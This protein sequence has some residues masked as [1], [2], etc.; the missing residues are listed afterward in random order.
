[1]QLGIFLLG[2]RPCILLP[3]GKP[4]VFQRLKTQTL[5]NLKRGKNLNRQKMPKRR[6]IPSVKNFRPLKIAKRQEGSIDRWIALP[7]RPCCV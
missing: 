2:E 6:R 3:E 4:F 1:M 7:L 5:K